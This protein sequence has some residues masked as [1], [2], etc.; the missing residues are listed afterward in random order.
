MNQVFVIS[1]TY[2]SVNYKFKPKIVYNSQT[3]PD[4]A[5]SRSKILQIFDKKCKI[6]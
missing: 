5:I 4:V 6:G 3:Y 1:K 2:L